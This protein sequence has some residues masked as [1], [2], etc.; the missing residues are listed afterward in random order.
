MAERNTM[1]VE[2]KHVIAVG[3]CSV[4]AGLLLSLG[5]SYKQASKALAKDG[6][7]PR[8]QVRV[9][10]TAVA[11]LLAST[12]ATGLVGLGGWYLLQQQ[13]VFTKEQAEVPTMSSAW[14]LVSQGVKGFWQDTVT[15]RLS[16]SDDEQR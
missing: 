10:P 14:G 6:I 12:V 5:W 3:A 16:K 4:G 9:L 11:A 15:A 1:E 13:E 8:L 7:D 2:P